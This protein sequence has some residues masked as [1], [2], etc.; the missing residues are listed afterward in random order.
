MWYMLVIHKQTEADH[1]E[2]FLSLWKIILVEI[3]TII[4]LINIS[5]FILLYIRNIIING[6]LNYYDLNT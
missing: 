3:I 4:N 6:S 2:K 1:T 5:Y